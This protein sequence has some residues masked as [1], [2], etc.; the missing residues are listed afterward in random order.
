MII[1][2]SIVGHSGIF[3]DADGN[4]CFNCTDPREAVEINGAIVINNTDGNTPGSIRYNGTGFE[5]R[6]ESLWFPLSGGNATYNINGTGGVGTDSNAGI[7][8]LL[9]GIILT[10]AIITVTL[11]K[12]HG[13]IQILFFALTLY[14]IL[15]GISIG[16][17][18]LNNEGMS[19][20]SS[21]LSGNYTIFMFAIIFIIA[22][23]IITLIYNAF[24]TKKDEASE[25]T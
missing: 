22:Y 2:F 3:I 19:E 21:L 5:G 14:F 4:V 25:S 18:M 9:L 11:D 8:I 17:N 12:K 20:L 7:I 1:S 15:T 10:L 6:N 24:A 23:I 16:M 13:A